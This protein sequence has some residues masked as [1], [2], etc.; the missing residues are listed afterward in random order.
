MVGSG[1]ATHAHQ[2]ASVRDSFYAGKLDTARSRLDKEIA[3]D[4]SDAEVLR[5]EHAIVDLVDGRPDEAEKTLRVVRDRFDYLEQKDVGESVLATVTDDNKLAYAGEDYEKILI[6]CFLSLSNL[7]HHGGDASAY[8]L[9][10]GEKQREIIAQGSDQNGNNPK[11]GYKRV[12]LGAYIHAAIQEATHVNYDE[13]TRAIQLVANWEPEFQPAQDDLKRLTTG[14]H[15]TKGDGVV[16][17]FGLVGRGPYK[18]ERFEQPTS[19]ALL[20]ADRILSATA[21]HSLPPTIAPIKVPVVVRSHNRIRSLGIAIDGEAK[22][23]TETITDIGQL[24]VDQ[25]QAV[26]PQVMARAVVRR[27][28]KKGAVYATKEFAHIN[29]PA[30]EL[31]MDLAG[32]AWEATESADTRCWGL[33]PDQIQVLRLELPAGEHRLSLTPLDFGGPMGAGATQS[34]LVEDGRSTY[35]MACF[36]DNHLVGQILVSSSEIRLD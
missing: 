23:H 12:A 21:K 18:E 35:V 1:C 10:V 7:M 27:V 8:A 25:Y 17:V 26:F 32:V 15:S 33:L 20:I 11:L 34:I 4:K 30:A 36:P 9:Q 31:A 16:Y 28:V 6:R 19:A 29:H 3:R 5:L 14:Q 22:G 2:L 13:A 24:A